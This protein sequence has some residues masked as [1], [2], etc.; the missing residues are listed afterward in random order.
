MIETGLSDL[1]Q[2]LKRY[3]FD[4]R[5][6]NPEETV[7]GL[8]GFQ[9][10]KN[11]VTIRYDGDLYVNNEPLQTPWGQFDIHIQEHIVWFLTNQDSMVRGLAKTNQGHTRGNIV[12]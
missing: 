5:E 1:I 8:A 12:E 11:G 7:S 10:I 4:V 2:E 6:L 3:N 9:A